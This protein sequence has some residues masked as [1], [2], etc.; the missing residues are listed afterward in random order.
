MVF[1]KT[2]R[3]LLSTMATVSVLM[4]VVL[5]F[6]FYNS[7]DNIKELENLKY[8]VKNIETSVL[9]LRRNEKDFLARYDL[10]YQAEFMKNFE[11]LI[12]SV[13]SI[14][15]GL[16]SYD[17]DGEKI[18]KLKVI[19]EQYSKNFNA[20]VAT[21]QKIGLNPEDGLYGS[22]RESVHNLEELLKKDLDYK[23]QTDMLMLRRAEK[24]FMLRSDLKYLEKFNKSLNVFLADVKVSKISDYD[25]AVSLMNAYVKDFYNLVEGYKEIGLTPNDGA[26]GNMRNT[27]HQVDESLKELLE[28]VNTVLEKKNKE[29]TVLIT[30]VFLFLVLTMVG[31]AIFVIN[32]I[33]TQ[34]KNISDSVNNIAQTKDISLLIPIKND[35]ELS[36]LAKNL[37]SMFIELRSVIADAK[38]S[39]VE[40]SSIS[41]ELS[42]TSMQV[43]RNVEESVEIINEAT[44][45]TTHI[46][47]EIARAVEDAKENKKEIERANGILIDAK[48]K[49]INLASKVQSGA[50]AEAELAKNIESLTKDMDQVKNVLDVISDIAEQTNL[51]ALNAAIEA[52][53]AGEHGRG[54]AVVADEVRKLAERTQKTL[55]EIN[56]TISIIVQ[57]SNAAHEQ[58]SINSGQMDELV[59]ISN[60]VESKI[61]LMADI[62]NIATKAND[63]TVNDFESTASNI[64]SI[65]N[66][67]A[68]INS[69]STKNARSVEEIA[70]ASE[71][72]NNMTQSLNGKLEQFRT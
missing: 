66:K 33:N 5:G 52:A 37:N 51:L 12:K 70:S 50:E 42:T 22:L 6:I 18:K 2:F 17:I 53:R 36:I 45:K 21:Q 72:L 57:S 16:K 35:D 27:I 26:L 24:D 71:H 55:T 63:K 68:E 62:V 46:T 58:M 3:A 47:N 9:K 7:I 4:F 56:S 31:F 38:H 41:H 59:G 10:K 30:V 34:I 54:F 64:I 48:S 40:N 49:I 25:Q 67:I 43:G 1:L 44:Q 29:I 39:S 65:S 20:I 32:K 13:E 61:G 15:Y 69:I 60:E 8:E 28:N 19:L 14:D 11:K 23:L